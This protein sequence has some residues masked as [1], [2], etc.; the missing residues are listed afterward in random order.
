MLF[1][2][3]VISLK[4]LFGKF[5]KDNKKTKSSLK[6]TLR[7]EKCWLDGKYTDKNTKEFKRKR[8]EGKVTIE[9]I[10]N[11]GVIEKRLEFVFPYSDPE[12]KDYV[13]HYVR[14]I[15]Q[16][17]FMYKKE[18]NSKDE[19]MIHYSKMLSME[20]ITISALSF[21]RFR[22]IAEGKSDIEISNLLSPHITTENYP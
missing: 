22:I 13:G 16:P 19:K 14:E 5:A 17:I 9:T 4:R 21:G 15:F 11:S 6:K 12:D 7:E 3:G 18:V 2:K 20:C 1:N 8:L 10:N